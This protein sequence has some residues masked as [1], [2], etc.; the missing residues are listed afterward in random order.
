MKS[1]KKNAGS[2]FHKQVSNVVYVDN[3]IRDQEV[4]QYF[5]LL[6]ERK[7][8]ERIGVNNQAMLYPL[9]NKI[10]K[11]H[12]TEY[13]VMV[14]R[15]YNNTQT[16]QKNPELT[17]MSNN[18]K[19]LLNT[20]KDVSRSCTNFKTVPKTADTAPKSPGYKRQKILEQSHLRKSAYYRRW[21]Y[22]KVLEKCTDAYNKI[23]AR[24]KKNKGQVEDLGQFTFGQMYQNNLDDDRKHKYLNAS[25]YMLDTNKTTKSYRES[26]YENQGQIDD[27]LDI[28][29]SDKVSTKASNFRIKNH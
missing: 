1:D 14:N 29:Q 20:N 22:S 7:L 24:A 28:T 13:I 11:W 26:Y 15:L 3:L 6:N 5:N 27:I 2:D 12:Q 9:N 19:M 17:S 21:N 23:P 18:S 25:R 4:N 16:K 10:K 8:C